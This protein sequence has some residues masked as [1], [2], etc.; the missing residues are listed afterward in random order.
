MNN[1]DFTFFFVLL[2]KLRGM[3]YYV[4]FLIVICTICTI[5]GQTIEFTDTVFKQKLLE[6]N[7]VDINNDGEIQIVEAEA[8]TVLQLGSNPQSPEEITDLQGIEYFINLEQLI[9]FSNFLTEVDL[10]ALTQLRELNMRNNNLTSINLGEGTQLTELNLK[11]NNLSTIDLSTF[12][13]LDHLILEGN[14]LG[15]VNVSNQINATYI[16]VRYCGLSEI[17]ITANL[18]LEELAIS[19]N[20]LTTIDLSTTPNMTNLLINNNQLTALDIPASSSLFY[21]T[22]INNNITSLDLENRVNLTVLDVSLNNIDSIDASSSGIMYLHCS[23]NPNL[24][25]INTNNEIISYTDPDLLFF[26]FAFADLPS[27]VDVIIDCEEEEALF[28]SEYDEANV[29]V[30]CFLGVEDFLLNNIRLYPN[31]FESSFELSSTEGIILNYTMYTLSGK[32]IVT[33]TNFSEI[34]LKASSLKSGIYFLEMSSI[35]GNKKTL[36]VIKK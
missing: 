11:G 34:Q 1:S 6:D 24:S 25:Y 16:N 12:T 22:A 29:T 31:P 7:D 14:P 18:V 28:Y 13:N 3:K 9:C 20:D 15:N 23:S 19:N 35:T 26:P 4:T 17:D 2:K 8:M 32:Q 27:L 5:H 30:E 10:S 33:S 21:I 36:K